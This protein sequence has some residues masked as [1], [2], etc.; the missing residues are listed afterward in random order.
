MNFKLITLVGISLVF[1]VSCSSKGWYEGMKNREK[2]LC[3]QVPPSEYEDCVRQAEGNY[4]DY[5]RQREEI[6]KAE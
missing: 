6:K 2:L 5:R 3:N 4:E 1:V